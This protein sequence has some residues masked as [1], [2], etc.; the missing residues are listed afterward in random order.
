VAPFDP[1][2]Y[3]GG[4]SPD[5]ARSAIT[6]YV[7]QFYAPFNVQI[8]TAR[9]A[10]GRYTMCLVGDLPE[11]VIGTADAAGIA[12]RDCDNDQEDN[13]TYAFSASLTPR[14]TG[15]S[16]SQ[17][18]KAIAITVAQ[19]TAHAFGLSHTDSDVDL[20]YPLLDE[21][22]NQFV[23]ETRALIQNPSGTC[24]NAT[25]QNSKQL[26][27]SIIG[28]GN[29]SGTLGPAPTVR[30]T[31]PKEG[32]TVPLSFTIIV[33]AQPVAGSSLSKVRVE[34]GPELLSEWTRPPYREPIQVRAGGAAE[35][36]A[37]AFDANGNFQSA[38]VRF[39]IKAG[40]PPQ[41]L[42][43]CTQD[44]ECELGTV[45]EMGKCARP[46]P[47]GGTSGGSDGGTMGGTTGGTGTGAGIVG[48]PCQDSSECATGVCAEADGVKFCTMICD[49]TNTSS[50]PGWLACRPVGSSSE[51]YC[52]PKTMGRGCSA[53]PARAGGGGGALLLGGLLVALAWRR[54]RP[55]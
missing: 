43:P 35:M 20:M 26:L 17:S 23:D 5:Q 16:L 8:V 13:I 55:A 53:I 42:P 6:N 10:T 51:Y 29:G 21:H 14:Q 11:T 48:G 52:Q 45:C 1:A 18:L 33:D 24:H 28:F 41:D 37:T 3:A 38:S 31:E 32:A 19:E 39:T 9:P 4:F 47:T 34:A 44:I 27:G 40:A 54:R 36:V 15:R 7:R 22:Q 49:P 30:F 50:C 46:S 2:P 25:T 12:P